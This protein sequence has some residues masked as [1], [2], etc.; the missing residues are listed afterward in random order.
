MLHSIYKK[1]KKQKILLLTTSFLAIPTLVI[2]CSD[3]HQESPKNIS[4]SPT[5]GQGNNNPVPGQGNNNPEKTNPGN[6]NPEKTN[7]EKGS[8]IS[9]E[10]SEIISNSVLGF[11]GQ[12][13]NPKV[14]KNRFDVTKHY[15]E[16]IPEASFISGKGGTGKYGLLPYWY[17]LQSIPK[18]LE[19]KGFIN[20]NKYNKEEYLKRLEYFDKKE[21]SYFYRNLVRYQNEIAGIKG[22]FEVWK[23]DLHNQYKKIAEQKKENPYVKYKDLINKDRIVHIENIREDDYFPI[24]KPELDSYNAQIPDDKKIKYS[25][26][27]DFLLATERIWP[28]S[29]DKW[30]FTSYDEF[31][32]DKA[33]YFRDEYYIEKGYK[34]SEPEKLWYELGWSILHPERIISSIKTARFIF[35]IMTGIE[36]QLFKLT[37][38]N[39]E[40]DY[41]LASKFIGRVDFFTDVLAD[42]LKPKYHLNLRKDLVFNIDIS[43]NQD[44]Q[45]LISDFIEYYN[46]KIAPIIWRINLKRT[47]NGIPSKIPTLTKYFKSR[48]DGY[49][50]NKYLKSLLPEIKDLPD[51]EDV[52]NDKTLSDEAKEQARQEARKAGIKAWGIWLKTYQQKYGIDFKP[53]PEIDQEYFDYASLSSVQKPETSV[54]T[55]ESIEKTAPSSTIDNT[56]QIPEQTE[57]IHGESEAQR[58]TVESQSEPVENISS[59][60]TEQPN[61]IEEQTEVIEETQEAVEPRS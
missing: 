42:F 24:I 17:F 8:P 1:L 48:Y 46:Q 11:N 18:Y 50:F 29:V 47:Y 28:S 16:E 56:Q 57:V 58:G 39:K 14:A 27:F 35:G 37:D 15:T 2:S 5:P 40:I 34:P 55:P 45:S 25:I 44:D 30:P 26:V 41:Q 51:E 10:Y 49:Y 43:N 61:N 19:N 53:D 9:E 13:K 12:K 6:T 23:E 20:N 7:P 38:Q 21:S 33:R 32:E 3:P 4:K 60:N 36:K 22:E 52:K 31:R 54:P 59:N